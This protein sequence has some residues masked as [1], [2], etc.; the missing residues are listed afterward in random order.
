ML[1]ESS[2]FSPVQV[3]QLASFL[4]RLMSRSSI[5]VSREL[6]SQVLTTLTAPS[7][8]REERQA[9][10][11][12]ILTVTSSDGSSYQTSIPKFCPKTCNKC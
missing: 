3:G 11:L 2:P 12:D 10:L 6:Y 8:Q 5:L 1:R 4:A 7:A 9:A